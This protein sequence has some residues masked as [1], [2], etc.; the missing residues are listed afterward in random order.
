ML[1]LSIHADSISGRFV[2]DT[3]FASSVL[4]QVSPNETALSQR[5]DH[6]IQHVI[7]QL[8][9]GESPPPLLREQ[10]PDL[11][12]F[13]RE[14]KKL[15]LRKKLV[16]RRR[17]VGSEYTYQLVLHSGLMYFINSTINGSFGL[18]K[19]FGLSGF[20]FYFYFTFGTC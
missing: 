4:P 5:A 8:E 19:E 2:D 11:P 18:T 20:S 6:V 7:A 3:L 1:S 14:V 15:E 17:Q 16:V 10:L 9:S 12:L 13:L